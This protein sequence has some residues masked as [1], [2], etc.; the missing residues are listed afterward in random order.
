MNESINVL[1][2]FDGISCGRV[3]LERAGFT[4]NKYYSSEIEKDS[5]KISHKN[6]PD[7]VQLGDIRN[8]T[9]DM[10]DNLPTIHI[11]MGGSPC[12]DLSKCKQDRERKGLMGEKSSLFYEYVRILKKVKPKYFLLENVQMDK[13]YEDEITSILGV[14]PIEINSNLVTAQ[15][16]KRL[17]WTNIPNITQ[18][19]DKGIKLKDIVL[20]PT[21]VEDKYWY[22]KEFTYNG[23]D[24]KIQC[25]LHINT[26]NLLKSVYNLN[27]K[28]GTLTCV[29]GGYQEKKVYQDGRCRKL[30]PI[31][32]ERLQTLP[33]GYTEGVSNSKRYSAIGNGWTVDIITHI[34]KHINE[35]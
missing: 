8:I 26:H 20:S 5:I 1:S 22:E 3:A 24:S 21:E 11:L 35:I 27:N 17:Y 23:D 2:L 15:D 29:R 28:C 10:L 14:E 33:D 7:I 4:I 12:Q 9:D 6:Y 19:N 13:V 32:Y 31:E 16:R 34:L 25:T 30:T 18:P